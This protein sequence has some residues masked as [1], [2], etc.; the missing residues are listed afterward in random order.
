M[1]R[2]RLSRIIDSLAAYYGKQHPPP[3]HGAFELLLW[4]KVAYLADDAKRA[5]AFAALR[6]RVGLTPSAITAADDETLRE[7][8]AVGGPIEVPKRVRNMRDAADYV[9]AEWDGTLDVALTLP[10]REAR[11]ALQKFAGIG[12]PGAD[13]ILLL[14]RSQKVLALDSNGARALLRL[15]YGMDHKSYSTM[16]KSVVAA[17]TPELVADYDSLI[18]AH[19]LLRHHGQQTCKTNEP[20]CEICPVRGVCDFAHQA[21]SRP[22]TVRLGRDGRER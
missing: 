7:C 18:D 17:A 21:G 13:K 20:H 14:T 8:V 2:S 15:G 4:E 3:A 10:L 22:N 1:T 19:V 11:R 9:I 5:R 16:Y 12:E 6:D